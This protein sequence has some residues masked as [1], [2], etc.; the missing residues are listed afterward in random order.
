VIG[1]GHQ[2]LICNSMAPMEKSLVPVSPIVRSL[3]SKFHKIGGDMN[4][5]FNFLK[6]SSQYS[7]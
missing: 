7:D 6:E 3:V 4:Q 2:S 1:G 5:F